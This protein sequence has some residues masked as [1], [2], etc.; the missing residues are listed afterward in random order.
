MIPI[1]YHHLYYFW[2]TAKAGSMT[3]AKETL[4]LAQPTLSLQLR[5]LE[6]FLGKKL[7]RRSRRGISLTEEGRIAFEYGERIFTQGEELIL[8]LGRK[9]NQQKPSLTLGLSRFL[10]RE[11][12]MN[13][14]AAAGGSTQVALFSGSAEELRMKL[15]RGDIDLAAAEE[16][17]FKHSTGKFKCRLAGTVSIYFVS[18][19]EIKKSLGSFPPL[20]KEAALLVFTAQNPARRLI[21]EG[22]AKFGGR[23]A[24]AA[25]TDDQDILRQ[26]AVQ[27]KGVAT[28]PAAFIRD[29]LAEGRLVRLDRT[30]LVDAPLWLAAAEKP[31]ADATVRSKLRQ[32]MT[33]FRLNLQGRAYGLH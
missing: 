14:L 8:A 24:I 22:L 2:A 27:G 31:H 20:E 6:K 19:P 33:A 32:M 25:E 9:K 28:L 21:D 1:N 29:E 13:V 17:L 30:A 10:P 5:R 3:R 26:L 16:N 11:L 12:A 23:W 15:E 4:Q 18:T 7:Y